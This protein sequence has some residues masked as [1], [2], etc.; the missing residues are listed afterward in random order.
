MERKY[1]KEFEKPFAFV[2]IIRGYNA[3]VAYGMVQA[4]GEESFADVG[5]PGDVSFR[6]VAKFRQ[7]PPCC[8]D[9]SLTP[10]PH[11]AIVKCGEKPPAE[12][13]V[14]DLR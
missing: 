3:V 4:T 13:G 11:F 9:P 1:L 5:F 8:L 14:E 2:L 7:R 12:P 6:V 10:T